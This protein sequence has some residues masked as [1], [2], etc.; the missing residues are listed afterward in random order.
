MIRENESGLDSLLLSWNLRNIVPK[1]SA[2]LPGEFCIDGVAPGEYPI[3]AWRP[4]YLEVPVGGRK[5]D[6]VGRTSSAFG[7]CLPNTEWNPRRTVRLPMFSQGG[8]IGPE[9]LRQVIRSWSECTITEDIPCLAVAV[10]ASG[11]YSED[12]QAQTISVLMVCSDAV[13][14]IV[15]L[16]WTEGPLE[17]CIT[18]EWCVQTTTLLN[19]HNARRE[20]EKLHRHPFR[21]GAVY[22]IYTLPPCLGQ[23]LRG[24]P[25]EASYKFWNL[26][27]RYT[28][29]PEL[30]S[31]L[32]LILSK[33][34]SLFMNEGGD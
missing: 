17:D 2:L 18:P 27:W 26:E 28:G 9:I 12:R 10:K 34:Q 24:G 15:T 13:C 33:I 4:Y 8:E 14:R 5:K 22:S 32:T 19:L 3:D 6:I 30:I 21:E 23:V 16:D 25:F 31:D 29:H 7:V 11:T 20:M 1:P